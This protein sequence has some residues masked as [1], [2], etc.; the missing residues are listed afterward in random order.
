MKNLEFMGY[1]LYAVTRDGRV[2]SEISKRFLKRSK[3][4]TSGRYRVNIRNEDGIKT[5]Y[6]YRLVALAFLANPKNYE[7]VNHRD[8]DPTNDHVNNLEWIDAEGNSIHAIQ[9]GLMPHRHLTVE[10]AHHVFSLMEE[11]YRNCDIEEITGFSYAVISKM[12]QG[13]NYRDLWE[14]YDVPIKPHTVSLPKAEKVIDLLIAG[15]N[16]TQIC[17]EL[18]IGRNLVKDIRDGKRFRSLYT[19]KVSNTT[20]NDYP[21]G[22]YT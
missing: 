7:M 1:P 22:E 15:V 18:N 16:T 12:R 17:L 10:S 14:Q 8:G 6:I 2:F 11:G 4:P 9:T 5:I 3:S 19:Q 21:L 13:A 20:C